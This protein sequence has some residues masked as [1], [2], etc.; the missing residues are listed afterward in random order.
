MPKIYN[1]NDPSI[2]I[3]GTCYVG[4]IVADYSLLVKKLGKPSASFDN[5]KTDAEWQIE[6]EDGTVATVYN[7]KNGKNYCGEDGLE[8]EDIQSWHIGG[9]E[10]CVLSWIEDYI[11]HSWPIFD[12]IR[13]EAQI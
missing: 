9:C 1:I 4:S 11:H 13:Q 6:F 8:V 2:N 10:S 12:E 5:Y 7:W 3:N